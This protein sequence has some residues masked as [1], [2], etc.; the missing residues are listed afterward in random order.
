M[1]RGRVVQDALNRANGKGRKEWCGSIN[2]TAD[3]I[4][5]IV[6]GFGIPVYQLFLFSEEEKQ[7]VDKGNQEEQI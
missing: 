4:E 1:G 3:N 5:K 7:K 6:N 2:I